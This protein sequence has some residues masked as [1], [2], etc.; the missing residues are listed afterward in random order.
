MGKYDVN[1]VQQALPHGIDSAPTE[2]MRGLSI[3]TESNRQTF[4]YAYINKEQVANA[5]ETRLY[6]TNSD[7][8]F[9]TYIYLRDDATIEIGGDTDN[10]VRYSE[11]KAGYD[12]LKTDFNNLVTLY[13]SHVHITTATVSA[14]PVP[15]IITP[16]PSQG[17]PST[18]S[19]AASKIDEIKTI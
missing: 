5:G 12:E 3:E 10:M 4:V 14:T 1:D 15:G 18:A 17:T 11:L 8:A 13:N 2:D 16:T 9:Q 6:S 19:I 7:G